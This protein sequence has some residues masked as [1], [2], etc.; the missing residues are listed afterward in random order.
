MALAEQGERCL[1]EKLPQQK[2]FRAVSSHNQ[3]GLPCLGVGQK[4]LP[5]I[6][7]DGV[8]IRVT[9]VGAEVGAAS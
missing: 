8:D 1:A 5:R 3:I 6:T 7:A 9:A 4:L 2:V